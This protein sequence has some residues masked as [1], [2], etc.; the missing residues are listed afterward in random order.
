MPITGVR[1]RAGDHDDLD[2]DALPEL[3]DENGMHHAT[4]IASTGFW[5]VAKRLPALVRE[6]LRLAWAAS[7]RDTVAAIVL[8]LIAGVLTTFGLLA[9]GSVLTSLFADGPTP[10][11]VR[12]ALPALLLAGA[13]ATARGGLTIA[14]GWA[15]SRLMPQINFQIELQMFEATTRM[16]LAAFDDHGLAQDM[17]RARSRGMHEGSWIVDA[18]VNLITGL[19]GVAAAG[20]AV[21]LIAP[22]LLPCLLVAALPQAITAIRVA[23][24]EYLTMVQRINRRRRMWLLASLLADRLTAAEIR[25]FQ[26]RDYLL[27]Q[28]RKMMGAETKALLVMVRSQT[29]SRIVGASLAGVATGALY[30]LL[31]TLLMDGAVPLAAAA[32]A[33]VALQGASASLHNTTFAI[34]RLYEDALYYSDFRHFLDRAAQHSP[35]AGIRPVDEV[36]EIGLDDVS[37]T[38]AG[39]AQPAVD[40]VTMTLRRGQVVALVGENGSGKTSLAKLIAG[41]YRPS[42]GHIRWDGVD[43]TELD[44]DHLAGKVAVVTQEFYKFPFAV[45]A[46]IHLGRHERGLDPAEIQAAARAAA[47]HDMIVGLPHGYQTLLSKEFKDGHDLSGGQWQRLVAARGLYRDATVLLADEPSSALDANAEHAFFQQLRPRPDRIVVLITHRLANV[48]YAD[49]IYVLHEGRVTEQGGHDELMALGGRY[50]TLFRL[51]AAGY[52]LADPAPAGD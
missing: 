34:N 6:S 18:S 9:T 42:A 36:T 26:M 47:A 48:R 10:D 7:P 29:G 2:L 3:A 46:N 41:L 32:T 25:A 38:Y 12:D 8:Q 13:A 20:V 40:G 14:A 31:A 44:P 51:Q 52:V 17:D 16:E 11:R 27:G 50:A 37:F 22:M 39:T 21:A 45:Q 1:Q 5:A 19:V 23:R 43:I 49:V 30:L 28:Y 35:S 33:M 4:A 24:R 15:Q